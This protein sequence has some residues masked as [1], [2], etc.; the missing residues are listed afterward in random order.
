M[1]A[2]NVQSIFGESGAGN[3]KN[4]L[5]QFW[6]G[7]E[8]RE[9]VHIFKVPLAGFAGAKGDLAKALWDLL[10]LNISDILIKTWNEAGIMKKYLNRSEYDPNAEVSVA[11][12]EHQIKSE[13]QPRLDI[14]LD[15]KKLFEIVLDVSLEFSLNSIV[16][17]I[18]DAK[19]T[20]IETG[21]CKAGGSVSYKGLELLKKDTGDIELPGTFRF[22]RGIPIAP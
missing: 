2:Q 21:T 14:L 7:N 18:K 15:G 10:D 6:S 20:D 22:E 8:L 1:I 13:H 9:L 16:L 12:S 17:K 19:I 4:R 11:L 3:L 5:S